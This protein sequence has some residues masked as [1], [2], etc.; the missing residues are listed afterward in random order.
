MR[1]SNLTYLNIIVILNVNYACFCHTSL[2]Q[3]LIY[4]VPAFGTTTAG[5]R[6]LHL[7]GGPKK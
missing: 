5:K 1:D 2:I 4:F 7:Q 6:Y 3:S